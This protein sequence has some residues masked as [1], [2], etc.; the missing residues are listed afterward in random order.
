MRVFTTVIAVLVLSAVPSFAGETPAKAPYYRPHNYRPHNAHGTKP[1]QSG[2][3]VIVNAASFELG[4]SPGAIATIF[5]ENLT[6]VSG[7]V[8]AQ[9][10]P[11]PTRLAGVEVFISGFPAPIYS[12]AYANG[13]DQISI[14]VPYEAPTGPRAAEI[15]VFDESSLVADFFTDSF[16]EDPGIFV[17]NGSYAIA[18]GF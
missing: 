12:I 6:T 7:V 17:Y 15:Q 8:L 9:T 3:P 13:E 1:R 14:Q 2:G 16:T 4:I 18:E 5:G 11:L 10:D